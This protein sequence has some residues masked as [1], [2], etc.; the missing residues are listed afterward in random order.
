VPADDVAAST[1]PTG[2]D[3]RAAGT[4]PSS[5]ATS[6][7]STAVPP[8]PNET[9][10]Q[11]PSDVGTASDRVVGSGGLVGIAAPVLVTPAPSETLL[12]Q[13]VATRHVRGAA[14]ADSSP[15]GFSP[16]ASAVGESWLSSSFTSATERAGH[17]SPAA[18]AA[19]TPELPGAP[20]GGNG[21]SASG[22][23]SMALYALLLAFTALAL[24]RY[25]RLQ[26]RPVQWRCAAFV[27]LLE[28]PG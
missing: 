19:P 22:S 20:A 6:G 3:D 27:A 28:R 11:T 17:A 23:A 14:P 21:V 1:A 7:D 5:P 4:R 15:A 2:T 25:G 16:E 24:L 18:P 10:S 13:G 12:D 9:P 8:S 26:L